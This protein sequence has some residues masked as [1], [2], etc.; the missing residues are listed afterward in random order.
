MTEIRCSFWR[1]LLPRKYVGYNYRESYGWGWYSDVA[2]I[3]YDLWV[4]VRLFHITRV[5]RDGEDRWS[6]MILWR[7][8]K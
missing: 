1:R 8:E 4:K 2:S 7:W 3:W 6:R 5:K